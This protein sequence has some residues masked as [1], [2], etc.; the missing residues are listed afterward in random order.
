MCGVFGRDWQEYD[1]TEIQRSTFNPLFA[2]KIKIPYSFEE[3][4]KLRF[5]LYD[6]DGTLSNTR[7]LSQH[8]L[9]GRA[10]CTLGEIVS[11][12]TRTMLLTSSN[13]EAELIGILWYAVQ[14]L[15]N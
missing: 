12:H 2:N 7:S 14:I 5:H 15:G 10:E 1:R 8:E 11:G 4:Q 13:G 6:I 9:I 3:Q